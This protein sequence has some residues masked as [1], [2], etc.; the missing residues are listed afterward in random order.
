MPTPF[1]SKGSII[2]AVVRGPLPSPAYL[3]EFSQRYRE[4]ATR[5]TDS[6][7]NNPDYLDHYY[8]GENHLILLHFPVAG[9]DYMMKRLTDD[10]IKTA[11]DLSRMYW[12]WHSISVEP[13][14]LFRQ[15]DIVPP[16]PDDLASESHADSDFTRDTLNKDGT[17]YNATMNYLLY[18]LGPTFLDGLDSVNC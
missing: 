12:M 6:D 7:D 5:Y 18:L 8:G 3:S 11:N 4:L 2:A 16:W 17:L 13:T 9:L 15:I 14:L 10:A 1:F